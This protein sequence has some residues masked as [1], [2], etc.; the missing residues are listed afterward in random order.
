MAFVDGVNAADP[1]VINVVNNM[2]VNNVSGL[3]AGGI[4]IKDTLGANI[5]HNTI[6][7]NDSTATA[8]AAFPAGPQNPS[9]PYPAGIVS[10]AHSPALAASVGDGFSNPVLFDNIIWQNRSF[11]WQVDPTTSSAEL[12]PNAPPWDY[13]DLGVL[14]TGGALDPR[15]CLLTDVTGYD[16]SNRSGDPR[17]FNPYFNGPSNLPV[18]PENTTPLTAAALDEGGN[19]IDVRYGPLTLANAVT[20]QAWDYHIQAGSEAIDRG[21]TVGGIGE[22]GLDYDGEARPV[23]PA[24]DMGADESKPPAPPPPPVVVTPTITRTAYSSGQR[25]LWV[26]ATVNVGGGTEH[27]TWSPWKRPRSR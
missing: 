16:A 9:T 11:F 2:I 23:G 8:G 12:F 27:R 25:R 22:L 26:Y 15:Y 20:G 18:M 10:R 5:I 1:F 7:S 13:D 17:F 3:A 14:G 21:T 19:F 24:V 6:A 4:A